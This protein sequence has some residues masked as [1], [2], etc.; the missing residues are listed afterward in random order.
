MT[1]TRSDSAPQDYDPSAVSGVRGHRRRGHPHHVRGPLQ[2]LLV[3]RG[4]APF[5]GMWAIPGGFKRPTETLD[6][7]A[8]RELGEETGVDAASLLTQ[9]GA[10]GDPERDPRMNVVTVAYLAVLRDVEASRGRIGRG[11][12]RT[13]AGLRSPQRQGRARVRPLTDP[14]R[15]DR[16]RP[17]RARAHGHRDGVRRPDVH[18]GRAAGG[19]RG[20]LGRPA[21]RS[22]LPAQ[23][24]RR[25][26]L[27]RPDRTAGQARLGRRQARRALSTRER[28][29]ARRPHSSH[30]TRREGTLNHESSCRRPIRAAGGPAHRGGRATRSDGR[31]GPRQ[32]PRLD[33]HPLGLR[34]PCAPAR[35]SAAS[36]PGSGG[37]SD[38]S[39]ARSSPASSRRSARASPEFAV[40]DEVFGFQGGANA[41]YVCVPEDGAIAHKPA[42]HELRGGGAATATARASPA[43]A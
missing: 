10:Y 4:E 8:R 16:A 40:G 39:S 24:R 35:S 28:H 15:R 42:G 38:G 2:V 18:A 31:R 27:G 29:G 26:G 5:E 19:V 17:R 37:R 6:E 43:R 20:R 9:F 21:R 36:S 30:A 14:A 41:E 7:A 22:E 11:G 13:P 25:G 34:L 33:G 12:R 23:H 32:R 1:K 3:C